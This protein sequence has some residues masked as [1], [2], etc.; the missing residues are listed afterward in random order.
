[1]RRRMA[2]SSFLRSAAMRSL[3]TAGRV[4][5]SPRSCS[6]LE[7]G[8]LPIECTFEGRPGG[9][10]LDIAGKALVAGDNVGVLENP[11][12][13]GHHQIARREAVAIE[14]GLVAERLR[15][16]G[17]T[18]LHELHGAGAA[19]LGPFLIG[20]ED[21]D[22]SN[23]HHERLD[24]I[25]RGDQPLRRAGAR[26]RL[27]RQQCLAALADVEHD[28]ARL[29]QH[30]AVLLKDRHLAEGLQRAI[31]QLVLIALAEEPRP[32]WQAG[33]LQRPARAQIAHLTLSEI[34]DPSKGRN[35]DHRYPPHF[36]IVPTG[37]IQP[38]PA[39]LGSRSMAMRPTPG[40]SKIGITSSAPALTALA[41]RAS[42]SST[43]RNDIQLSGTPSNRGEVRGNRP[44]TGLPPSVATQYV[45]PSG[46][47]EASK[48]HPTVSA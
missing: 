29:E 41:T 16:A 15:K 6:L 7:V 20:V 24:G 3:L 25:E 1:M 42:T 10:A 9:A 14:I 40:T 13:R 43:A 28:G 4:G 37:V 35:R 5:A 21:I 31:V 8:H 22:P 46:V 18:P 48:L 33:L 44:A 26:P 17:K 38:M 36:V 47:A 45:S 11:E 34:R 32:V 19:L 27:L 12:H 23:F 39:P 30:E 2:A